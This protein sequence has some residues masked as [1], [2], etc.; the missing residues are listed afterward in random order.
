[1]LGCVLTGVLWIRPTKMNE[2]SRSLW[3][4]LEE[5]YKSIKDNMVISIITILIENQPNYEFYD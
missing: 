5:Y 2:F 3:A 4:V 1:M